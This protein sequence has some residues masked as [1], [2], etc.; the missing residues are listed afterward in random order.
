MIVDS[1]IIDN[2]PLSD[3]DIQEMDEDYREK[4]LI[5]ETTKAMIDL[6]ENV[7]AMDAQ[8]DSATEEARKLT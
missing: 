4:L 1:Q 2:G 7:T 8:N 5:N 3:K 6:V